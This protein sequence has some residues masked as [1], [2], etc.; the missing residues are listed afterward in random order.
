MK[1][2]SPS[3]THAPL[4]ASRA[5]RARSRHGYQSPERAFKPPGLVVAA[6]RH[7]R[8]LSGYRGRAHTGASKE[9]ERWLGGSERAGA[10]LPRLFFDTSPSTPSLTCGMHAPCRPLGATAVLAVASLDCS[11][12][13]RCRRPH[14]FHHLRTHRLLPT[15][16]GTRHPAPYARTCM[17][18]LGP[19]PRIGP[20]TQCRSVPLSPPSPHLHRSAPHRAPPPSPSKRALGLCTSQGCRCFALEPSAFGVRYATVCVGTRA[21]AAR[22]HVL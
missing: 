9:L 1:P 16:A 13:R 17:I 22:S 20:T 5:L 2:R 7:A 8:C 21:A 18:S 14:S 3:Q 11:T 10:P 4:H 19:P 6:E 15:S 12:R